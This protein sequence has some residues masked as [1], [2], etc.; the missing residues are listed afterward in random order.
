MRGPLRVPLSGAEK[1]VEKVP[2]WVERLLI[3]ILESRIRSIVKEEVAN[4]KKIVD[5]RF[6]GVNAK[7][8][9]LGGWISTF[10]EPI[11]TVQEMPELRPASRWSR[12][13]GRTGSFRSPGGRTLQSRL[14]GYHRQR[15]FRRV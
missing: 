6:E 12:S 5:A 14:I 8:D 7:L 15:P 9:A 2:G 13:V 4:L 10:E 3:P 1:V 11:P